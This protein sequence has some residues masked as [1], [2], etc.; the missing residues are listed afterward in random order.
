MP[1]ELT[2]VTEIATALGMLAPSLPAALE[3][4]P[5]ELLNVPDEAWGRLVSSSTNPSYAT[6]FETAFN[7]GR[8]FLEA[9]EALRGRRP[10]RVEWKGPHRPPA[11]D[12]IPA[13]L[14]IDHVFLVSCKYLSRVLLNPG[15]QRLFERLLVGEYRGGANWFADCAP[16]EFQTFYEAARESGDRLHALWVLLATTGMR[17]GEAIGVRWRDVALDAGRVRVVQTITQVRS[18]VTVGEPK[19]ARGR[20]YIALDGATVAVLRSHRTRM[21][22]ER[23]LVG[24]D[25][26]DEDLV[27]H[28]PDGTCLRPDAVS[29]MF[30]RRYGLPMLTLHGLR[31]TWATLGPRAR[32]APACCAGTARPLDDRRDP[33]HLQ[34]RR[35]NAP[36]RGGWPR[37]WPR[38]VIG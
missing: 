5:P 32:R 23:L 14:R 34:P 6:S 19:T 7:N 28:Q 9:S 24:A 4:R 29:A 18:A 12:G 1:G 30:V 11:D 3:A 38:A 33:R 10:L 16:N 22:G 37:G 20:R 27:F 26:G 36:R 2:E 31:H 25:F 13:D 21:L 17:R 8:A 15:P 35:A